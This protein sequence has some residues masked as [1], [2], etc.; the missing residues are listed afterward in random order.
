MTDPT[1]ID[2][3]HCGLCDGWVAALGQSE[4]EDDCPL[5]AV[6]RVLTLELAR[7]EA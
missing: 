3:R 7:R 1:T 2:L 6:A 5:M 4:V